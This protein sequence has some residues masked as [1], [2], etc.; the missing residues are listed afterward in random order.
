[1]EKVNFSNNYIT[2][3]GWESAPLVEGKSST[4]G[5]QGPSNKSVVNASGVSITNSYEGIVVR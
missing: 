3:E 1:M 5:G 4:I 2:S